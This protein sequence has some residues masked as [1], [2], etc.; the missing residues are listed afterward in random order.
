MV[1][2][3]EITN[4]DK[5]VAEAQIRDQRKPVDYNTIEYPV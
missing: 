1:T 5:E 2:Q 3:V 4:E